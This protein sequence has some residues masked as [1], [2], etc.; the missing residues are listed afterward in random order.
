[1]S[2]YCPRT[3]RVSADT[4]ITKPRMLLVLGMHRSGTSAV[5]GTLSR[6]GVDFGDHLEPPGEDNPK[7]YYEHVDIWRQD[8]AIL[9]ALGSVW[10]DPLPLPDDWQDDAE[11]ASAHARM[12][13]IVERDFANTGVSGIKDPRMCRLMP[14]WRSWLADMG[15]A[16]SVVLV[17]REPA[18]VMASLAQ[19]DH[20]PIDK[21]AWVWL[22][23]L[24]EAE[25]AT[26]D[27]PR[28][29]VA[30]ENLIRDW[31]GQ[32]ARI[33][34]TLNLLRPH[35]AQQAA[36][37]DAFLE[38]ALRHHRGS[39][40]AL[41]L[42]EPLKSWVARTYAALRHAGGAD[43]AALDQVAA[44]V[45]QADHLAATSALALREGRRERVQLEHKVQWFDSERQGLVAGN[46]EL[47]ENLDAHIRKL[48]EVTEGNAWLRGE[49][50]HLGG[51]VDRL[52]G[53]VDRV[54]GDADKL[55]QKFERVDALRVRFGAELTAVYASRSWRITRPVRGAARLART[56]RGRLLPG[57]GSPALPVPPDAVDVAP[58]SA[59]TAAEMPVAVD[60]MAVLDAAHA[61]A[62]GPRVLIVTPDILGPI[63]NGGIG[64]AFGALA[65]TLAE[66]GRAV[67]IVYTLG[68][69]NE[70][71]QG[72]ERWQRHYAA[73]GVRFIPAR[74]EEGEPTLDAP[75]HAWRAYRVYL[76]LKQHQQDYD[77]AYF[78]EWKGE[79]YYALQARRLGLDFAHLPIMVVTHSSTTWA[80]S[81][82]H[83]VPQKFEDLVLEFLERRS[84]EMADAVISPS[85]YMLDWVRQRGWRIGAPTHVIQN[86][87]PDTGGAAPVGEATAFNI[88]EWVFFGRLERRKGLLIFL[89]ALARMP[90]ELR[91]HI[92]VTFLGKAIHT[93]DFDS[94]A[95]I[96]ERMDGWAHAP[97]IITD[98]DR[99]QALAYLQQPGRVAIIASL[100]EN[101]PYTV[102]E[103]V[104]KRIPF[105]AADV[106]GIAE[107]I[108]PADRDRALFK[109]TPEGLKTALLALN[110]ERY[111][112]PRP[113]FDADATRQAWLDLQHT[114]LEQSAVAP[115]EPRGAAPHITVCLVHYNRPEMLAQSLDSLRQQTYAHFDVVLVDDGSPSPAA[116]RY[117]DKLQDEFDWRGWTLVRQTNAYLGAARNHAVRHA[118]GDYVL[119]MDDDNIAKPHELAV[120]A[121][122]AQISGADILTTVSDVFNAA[123]GVPSPDQPSQQLW[124][125]LGNA[126]GLGVFRNVFGDANA[127][128]RRRTFMS[129]GGFTE[130]V[131]IGHEDWEFFARASLAGADLQLLPEPLFWYRVNATSMLRAGD[132]RVDHARSVRPYWEQQG[133]GV[134]PALAYAMYMHHR[135]TEVSFVPA[136]P[137]PG[138]IMPSR[139]R[140][141][142]RLAT[143]LFRPEV[144]QHFRQVWRQ[145]GWR[146]LPG[147]IVRYLGR[148][149][150]RA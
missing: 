133:H 19:R 2:A 71:G 97:R 110:G 96:A 65:Q 140:R 79:A 26:R 77:L 21:A 148:S 20:M 136:Q 44:E 14:L 95:A 47:Q 7:G 11:V 123:D 34:D 89:D 98:H 66:D 57:A 54:N 32:T 36:A 117:L 64:T 137:T 10:D 143:G 42:A 29:I 43:T 52:S 22:R 38:S 12:Q 91:Q 80:E 55:R 145:S 142:W 116:Q 13:Q 84:T 9:E 106:G 139:L 15:F 103:C 24:L 8:H 46:A 45:A 70:D 114:L 61:A 17:T 93:S 88:T 63:R 58:Q 147:R 144:R 78:P 5:A 74:L 4:A 125:P 122:A 49:V 1:M 134:G 105:M 23:H 48:D 120:F 132:A 73:M 127:L 50:D 59:Q 130:D 138:A 101:S 51:E 90:E 82:N 149:G 121:R 112:P 67:T 111:A 6:L 60:P 28:A 113:A 129:V 25:R 41:P 94:E 62:T 85:Q 3:R 35:S 146:G 53:E 75:Y 150:P 102:L 18:G 27:M 119:F 99:D 69:H 40:D 87:M 141:V 68:N 76:W 33:D 30:Y 81:G 56:V 72:I 108:D 83:V 126:R 107:L 135:Q 124:V 39:T 92:Q 37:V 100:V 128:V 104:L 31:R 86:L 118:R 109:P 115:V 16:A 131:G